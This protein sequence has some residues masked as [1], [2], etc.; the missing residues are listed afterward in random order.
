MSLPMLDINLGLGFW[1]LGLGKIRSGAD[2]HNLAFENLQG[3][4]DQWVVLEIVFVEC[5]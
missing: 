1:F 5:N 4:L 2:F 3:F